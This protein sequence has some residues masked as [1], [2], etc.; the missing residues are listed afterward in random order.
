MA[1]AETIS[2]FGMN[3]ISWNCEQHYLP[4]LLLS[5]GQQ[6]HCSPIPTVSIGRKQR[7]RSDLKL[8]AKP[9]R[10]SKFP[11]EKDYILYILLNPAMQGPMRKFLYYSEIGN[12]VR[13]YRMDAKN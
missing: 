1:N 9:N 8:N 4:R 6:T 2:N 7:Y 13:S 11:R 10:D 5:A 3:K 12:L